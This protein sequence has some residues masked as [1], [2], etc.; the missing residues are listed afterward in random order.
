MNMTYWYASDPKTTR[1]IET[2]IC[3]TPECIRHHQD[4]MMIAGAFMLIAAISLWCIINWPEITNL[5]RE[6]I[7]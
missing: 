6:K 2:I 7:L 4:W 5:D 3:E 1:T